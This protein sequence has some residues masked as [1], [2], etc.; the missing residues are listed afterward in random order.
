MQRA[1]VDP[2]TSRTV[3]T[4][5]GPG[6]SGPPKPNPSSPV[7]RSPVRLG[8][9]VT[10]PLSPQVPAPEQPRARSPLQVAAI[11]PCTRTD[12]DSPGA[13]CP[14]AGIT[15]AVATAMTAQVAVRR[16]L[17]LNSRLFNAVENRR[18]RELHETARFGCELQRQRDKLAVD[19]VIGGEHVFDRR[20]RRFDV[21]NS[22]RSTAAGAAPRRVPRL[23]SARSS[24]E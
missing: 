1:G 23:S 13:A 12:A 3:R 18:S 22:R 9:K 5:G 15:P 17:F 19:G 14:D 2:G 16:P 11:T 4:S 6:S 24:S 21:G 10:D 7:S 20:R 8:L